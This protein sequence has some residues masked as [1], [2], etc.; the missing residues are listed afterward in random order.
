MKTNRQNRIGFAKCALNRNGYL[1]V[2]VLFTS[3]LLSASVATML[4][5]STASL[6]SKS[7]LARRHQARQLAESEIHRIAAIMQQNTTWRDNRSSGVFSNWQSIA[8]HDTG[9]NL[10]LAMDSEGLVRHKLID[11][12][13][14]LNDDLFDS[15]KLVAQAKVGDSEHTVS[16]SLT[17]SHE[18]LS[19]LSCSVTSWDDIEFDLGSSLSSDQSIQVDDDCK[20]D[21]S[22]IISTSLLQCG[23]VNEVILRGDLAGETI[24]PPMVDVVDRYLSIGTEIDRISLP[25]LSGRIQLRDLVISAASNPFG[26]T[27]PDAIYWIDG[28]NQQFDIQDC[29]INATLVFRNA[30][31]IVIGEGMV[32]DHPSD[33]AAILVTDS[34][35][36]F[37][38]L[39][40]TL[41]ESARSTNFNPPGTPFRGQT[42]NNTSNIFP[43]YFRGLI[44]TSDDID[45]TPPSDDT[46]FRL[47]GTLLGKDIAL[48]GPV[49]VTKLDGLVRSPPLGFTNLIP[50]EFVRGTYR[51]LPSP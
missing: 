26:A 30:N 9:G 33:A 31:E 16:V 45:I 37:E 8:V 25:T 39:T 6:Q 41:S 12:D 5:L 28:G 38:D 20:G 48:H 24:V 46:H 47:T 4:S 14:D 3:L 22:A 36:V 49:S 10:L 27:N 43:T 35:I 2:A 11:S 50:M 21:P 29:R 44:Y 19:L 34:P 51:R 7:S 13:G 1:Y 32:W 15:V 40:A 42:N 18:P 17:P 23:D